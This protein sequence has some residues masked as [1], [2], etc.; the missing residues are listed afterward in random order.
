MMQGCIDALAPGK[1]VRLHNDFHWNQLRINGDRIVVLDFERMC[2][3]DPL[4]DVANFACQLRMLGYRSEYGVQKQAA[5]R[6]AHL[7]LE[8]WTRRKG[9]R[10][11]PFHFR[12]FTALSL[13]ELARGMIRHLRCGWRQ[14][15]GECIELAFN[16]VSSVGKEAIAT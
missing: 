11:E 4:M 10:I 12:F 7:F 9:E 15:A 16:S 2:L 8:E 6:W 5:S 14:L 1:S 13:L 3:G